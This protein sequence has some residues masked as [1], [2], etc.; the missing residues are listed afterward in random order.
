VINPEEAES[1]Q[2]SRTATNPAD[3]AATDL[4]GQE[5]YDCQPSDATVVLR[6]MA[7]SA[8]NANRVLTGDGSYTIDD[9]V[10]ASAATVA[11][12]CEILERLVPL[13]SVAWRMPLADVSSTAGQ[14]TDSKADP[15]SHHVKIAFSERDEVIEIALD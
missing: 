4:A 7:E 10:C 11:A 9:A 15:P 2:H 13:L 8:A 5:P 12:V 1:G 6:K 14:D 3:D